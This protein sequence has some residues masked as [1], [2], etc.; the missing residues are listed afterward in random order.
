MK[1]KQISRLNLQFHTIHTTTEFDFFI[2]LSSSLFLLSGTI[3]ANLH[4]SKASHSSD[5]PIRSFIMG[6][7][8]SV[9]E[10]SA[11]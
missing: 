7:G 5:L 8:D 1:S 6:N 10:I 4:M 2:A 11:N 3:S 9:I